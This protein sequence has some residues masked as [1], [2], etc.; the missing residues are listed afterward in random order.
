MATIP[1]YVNDGQIIDPDTFG[2]PVVDALQDHED[3]LDALN[4]ANLPT[5]VGTAESEIDALQSTT[6][7]C[8]GAREMAIGFGNI[9]PQLL[10]YQHVWH[11][12]PTN[13]GYNNAGT[14]TISHNGFYVVRATINMASGASTGLQV[15]INGGTWASDFSTV[16][17]AMPMF[18]GWTVQIWNS[19]TSGATYAAGST[20]W[21]FR[22]GPI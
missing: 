7:T 21:I 18:A 19:T 9:N 2:N 8:G 22:V 15:R 12:N 14:W 11:I 16:T 17:L 13:I 20:M 5:R 3:R 1:A 4:G 10:N 6:M